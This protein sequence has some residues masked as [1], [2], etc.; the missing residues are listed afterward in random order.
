MAHL[1]SFTHTLP[2]MILIIMIGFFLRIYHLT[3]VPLRGDEAFSVQYWAGQ[4]LNI[5]LAQTATIEPHPVL[6]Y[7]VFRGWGVIAGTSELAMRLL[8][9]LAGL[10]G[11]PA[12]FAIGKRLGNNQIGLLAALLF[13]IHPFEIWHAQDARNYAIWAGLS[14]IALWLGLRALD[15]QR[16]RDWLLYALAASLAANIFYTELLSLAAFGAYVL[17][18]YWRNWKVVVWWAAAAALAVGLSMASFLIIQAP[19]FA[20]G[21]YTGSIGGAL[22][23]T[24]L[25]KHFLPVLNFGEIT[26]PADTLTQTWPLLLIV[27]L[28]GLVAI[29]HNNRRMAIALTLLG[30]IPPVLLAFISTKLD[31]FT[32]RY[33]L[34]TTPI[35]I[36]IFTGLVLYFSRLKHPLVGKT[37]S[38]LLLAGWI[39]I[40]GTSLTNYYFDP[41]YAKAR[42]WPALAHFIQQNAQPND[43]IIQSAADP[44]FGYYYHQS[45]SAI[46]PDIPL[47]QTPQQPIADIQ[48]ALQAYNQEKTAIWQV[49]QE[50][51]DWPNAGI[52][53]NWL[54]AHMQLVL[55]DNPGG[56]NVFAYKNW[57][58][59]SDEIAQSPFATFSNVTELVG[60][61]VIFPA[62]P[63]GELTVWLYWKP[64]KTTS[65]PLKIFVHLLGEIN[66]TTGSPL[67][68]QDDRYPQ[69]G[70]ISTETW[71]PSVVYRDVYTLPLNGM[72]AGMYTLELGLY[73]PA[74]DTRLPVGSADSYVLQSI[75]LK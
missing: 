57:Q 34:P 61:K 13:A 31:I 62:D 11:I 8:P 15:N 46:A 55:H 45:Q 17:I 32:P 24:R 58:V 21:G 38:M 41:A 39:T 64:L 53:K 19:L 18:I 27:L 67:W 33:V 72:L 40:S 29:W 37:V 35:Y 6:T 44:A 12:I 16:R 52:V 51:P 26:L 70:R 10:L 14:L 50:F 5:A 28:G 68:T 30:I 7:A 43:L 66:L 69:N 4:P 65:A 56:L 60:Y 20:R 42:D 59:A 54:D 47:P 75:Q 1:K 22:D 74:T 48:S 9:A 25:W 23:V 36:L 73:D 2:I 49:G 3:S 71:L 63:S